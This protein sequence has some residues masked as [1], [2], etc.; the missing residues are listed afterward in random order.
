MRDRG[1]PSQKDRFF[2]ELVDVNTAIASV[3]QEVLQVELATADKVTL[4]DFDKNTK[5][6]NAVPGCVQK[7]A[8]EGVE[9]NIHPTAFRLTHDAI[10]KRLVTRLEDAISW[11]FE[12][13]H[14]MSNLCFTADGGVDFGS[15][16]LSYLYSS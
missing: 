14:Q 2:P 9:N 15:Y 6:G 12:V 7:F 10:D 16:H 13:V 3:G 11:N 8:R 5:L 4:S 1:L